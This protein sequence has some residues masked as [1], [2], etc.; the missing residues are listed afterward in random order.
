MFCAVEIRKKSNFFRWEVGVIFVKFICSISQ[1]IRQESF[2][3]FGWILSFFLWFILYSVLFGPQFIA[4]NVP[5]RINRRSFLKVRS[6]DSIF[7]HLLYSKSSTFIVFYRWISCNQG[8]STFTSDI[9]QI[10]W[11]SLK[12]SMGTFFT[13][14]FSQANSFLLKLALGKRFSLG[15]LLCFWCSLG[16]T[17]YL[18]LFLH[19]LWR[20]HKGY[21]ILI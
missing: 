2:R 1:V 11:I 7:G 20:L 8:F 15:D 18:F 9:R 13:N 12:F 4:I 3:L 5:C 14:F 19:H 16:G 17:N 10:W 21:M 6:S